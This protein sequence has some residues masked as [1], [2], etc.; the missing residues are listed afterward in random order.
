VA[1]SPMSQVTDSRI[2]AGV[3]LGLAQVVVGALLV[4][5]GVGMWLGAEDGVGTRRAL[6]AA[7][8]VCAGLALVAGP[9]W[10]RLSHE[11]ANE[12]R[13]RIRAQERDE[14]AA[15]IHD[16]VLQTLALI[17]RNCADPKAV[18]TLARQQERELRTW[19]YGGEAPP[20][21]SLAAALQR[22]CDEVE[23][24]HGVKVETVAVGDAPVDQRL[25]ALVQSSREAL[26]NAA[27]HSGA[28]TASAYMEV[29]PD[30]VT[31]YVRDRGC[32]FDPDNIPSDRRG[33]SESIVGR[34]NRYG[35]KAA[36]RSSPGEGTEVEL[37][38]PR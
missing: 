32:G 1:P 33:I 2:V 30:Q 15:H 26:A 17:Q 24:L 14:V 25:V 22:M 3:A 6:V 36:I 8:A 35:G 18:A 19:L 7:A 16:S 13:E 11:L 5:A 4:A 21:E 27:R 38:M 28:P 23:D 37:V 31:V 9:W 12:R 29:E 10:W 34:M 20:D